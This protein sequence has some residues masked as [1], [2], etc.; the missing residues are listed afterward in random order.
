[1]PN[2]GR[3]MSFTQP[4]TPPLLIDDEANR[5]VGERIARLKSLV[6]GSGAQLVLL[7]PPLLDADDG[8]AGLLNTARRLG[9]SALRPVSSGA[10][11]PELYRDGFHLNKAGAA[12][13]TERL[14][15]ALRPELES[16]RRQAAYGVPV[17]VA[18]SAAP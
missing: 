11:G 3:L 2:V 10:F 7:L 9:V 12:Q 1:M 18:R 15:A 17:N 8:S 13:F 14:I 5:A 16:G 4:T 6:E